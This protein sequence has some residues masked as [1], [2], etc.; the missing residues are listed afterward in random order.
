MHK[1]SKPLKF[2]SNFSMEIKKIRNH[3]SSLGLVVLNINTTVLLGLQWMILT[4]RHL[5]KYITTSFKNEMSHHSKATVFMFLVGFFYLSTFIYQVPFVLPGIVLGW[6]GLWRWVKYF[7]HQLRE[8][9]IPQIIIMYCAGF[10]NRG[11]F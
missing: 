2:S 7:I 10:Y 6:L 11:A 4:L 1:P 3:C 8:A 5:G 9:Q